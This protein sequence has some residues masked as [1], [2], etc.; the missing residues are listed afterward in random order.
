M[1]GAVVWR[2]GYLPVTIGVDKAEGLGK[3]HGL[4]LF[5]ASRL[6]RPGVREAVHSVLRD[7]GRVMVAG[8]ARDRRTHWLQQ[9]YGIT[10][11]AVPL[12]QGMGKAKH[13]SKVE[14][15]DAWVIEGGTGMAW[16]HERPAVAYRRV[17]A[18]TLV[19]VGDPLLFLDAALLSL[20][21]TSTK[22]RARFAEYLI[23]GE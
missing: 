10:I 21:G 4:V 15:M 2:A 20:D 12:G 7:G 18:G 17:G 9:L 19:V 23:G 16:L 6:D 22:H 13:L 5:S 1:L 11:S 3:V 14:F 8:S